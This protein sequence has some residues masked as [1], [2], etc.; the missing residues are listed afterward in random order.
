MALNINFAK[1]RHPGRWVALIIIIVILAA[2]GWFGYKWYTTGEEVPILIPIVNADTAVD[3]SDINVAA[4]SVDDASAKYVSIPTLSV[5]NAR[6]LPVEMNDRNILQF[7]KNINDIGWYSKSATPG[8]GGV[9]VINGHGKGVSKNGPLV[10]LATLTVGAEIRIE[11]GD[12][13]PFRYEVIENKTLPY[14]EASTTGMTA[15]GKSAKSGVE[16]LNIIVPTGKWLPQLATFES[17]I[18]V[19]AT[20]IE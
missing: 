20:L 18:M 12:G 15:M 14:A 16:A 9:M 8:T 17:R 19:R 5:K 10:E 3:E 7:T 13:V 6:I 11:R 2:A 4:Y 1:E